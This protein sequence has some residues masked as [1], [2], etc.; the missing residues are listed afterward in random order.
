[1]QILLTQA[2]GFPDPQAG[3]GEQ[4]DEETVPRPGRIRDHA[5]DLLRRQVLVAGLA[6]LE[7][8]SRYLDLAPLATLAVVVTGRQEPQEPRL[9][10][11][12]GRLRRNPAVER[13]EA[14]EVRDRRHHRVRRTLR[15]VAGRSRGRAAAAAGRQRRGDQPLLQP[16]QRHETRTPPLDTALGAVA[17]IEGE[18]ARVD[19][20][21]VRRA[22]LAAQPRQKRTRLYMQVIGACIGH[23]PP[24][25]TGRRG[26][27]TLSYVGL[28]H[29]PNTTNPR[30]GP[31]PLPDSDHTTR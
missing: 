7:T 15:T 29:P 28:L 17:Q 6:D 30:R 27:R 20:F 18:T 14:Q 5:A 1:M 21:R 9:R 13:A 3:R 22:A 11:Q 2:Q 8:E 26:D 24:L 25:H 31:E 19:P 16:G 10:Q 12:A 23:H 4:R